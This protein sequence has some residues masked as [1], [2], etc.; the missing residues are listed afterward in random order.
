VKLK[1]IVSLNESWNKN[2]Y[3]AGAAQGTYFQRS[4]N[5]G[6]SITNSGATI[7]AITIRYYF[8]PETVLLS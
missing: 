8:Q 2:Y 3:T 6:A 1:G 4:V 7:T 5:Y